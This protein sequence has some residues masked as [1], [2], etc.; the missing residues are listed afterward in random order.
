VAAPRDNAILVT[1][2]AGFAGSHLLDRLIGSGAPIVG[3]YRPDMP[4]P[5]RADVQWRGV[6]LTDRASVAAAIAEDTPAQIYHLAGAPSVETSWTNA[7]PHLRINALGTHHLLE[8]VRIAGLPCRVLVVTSAQV[9][10][11]REQALDED[12]RLRPSTP[13]GLTK[14]AQD[15]LARQAAAEGI[16]AIVARPFNH[17]GPR[18]TAGF[19]IASFARQV[20]R[21][22]AGLDASVMRVGNLEPRRD[23]SDVRDVADA[24]V[25]LMAKGVSGREYNVC[26]GTAHRI[27]DVLDTL[28]RLATGSV[29][30]ETDAARLRPNDVPVVLGDATRIRSEI[31]WSPRIPFETTLRD[32]LD[33]WRAE[34]RAGR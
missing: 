25:R 24:Y 26:A 28:L 32:T 21:L 29:T 23:L 2:A 8:A 33:W 30:R 4:P 22:E 5:A 17:V 27:G 7:V 34:V 15:E 14:L 16:D 19:A 18:Q 6:E 13:Y 1:G 3:W 9:Y 11:T 12:S 20:A 31:G 10:E